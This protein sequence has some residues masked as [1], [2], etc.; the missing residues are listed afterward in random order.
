[1]S[2]QT[3]LLI[4]CLAEYERRIFIAD[5]TF[6]NLY[7]EDLPPLVAKNSDIIPSVGVIQT[8]EYGE[9]VYRFHGVGCELKFNS[10]IVDFDYIFGKFIYIGFEKFKLKLFIRSHDGYESL[11]DAATFDSSFQELLVRGIVIA[12]D[13]KNSRDTYEFEFRQDLIN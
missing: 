12:K 8:K 9:V 13:P 7:K 5:L 1:M 2:Q 3:E 10:T 4:Q 6:R 11:R